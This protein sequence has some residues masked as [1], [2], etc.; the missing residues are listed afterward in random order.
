MRPPS[1]DL[2]RLVKALSK[3]EKR[4]FK[5][6]AG[7]MAGDKKY[8]ELFDL[9]DR[10]ATYDEA[11][12]A[13][14]DLYGGQLSV[15]KNYL[16]RFLLKSLLY[17]NSEPESEMVQ[18]KEHASILATRELPSQALKYIRKSLRIAEKLEAFECMHELHAMEMEI[19]LRQP[20]E[21]EAIDKV[22]HLA[23]AKSQTRSLLENLHHYKDLHAQLQIFLNSKSRGLQQIEPRELLDLEA[24]EHLVDIRKAKSVRAK[25]EFLIT[26]RKLASYRSNWAGA[27]EYCEEALE[28]FDQHPLLIKSNLR[29]Y[30]S[31]LSHLVACYSAQDK[32]QEAGKALENFASLEKR[33]P[34]ARSEYQQTYHLLELGLA[35]RTGDVAR[36]KSLVPSILR[37]IKT[38]GDR[39]PL[40]RI[41]L[42]YYLLAY[43]HFMTGQRS[44][45]LTHLN[46]FLAEPRSESRMNFQALARLLRLLIFFEME[47]YMVVENEIGNVQRFLGKHL[48]KY[49]YAEAI[50]KAL[51]KLIKNAGTAPMESL[52]EKVLLDFRNDIH[53]AQ[54]DKGADMLD[55]ELWIKSRISKKNMVELKL[56]AT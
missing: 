22:L 38:A 43:M 44:Q 24:S 3:G 4:N 23:K 34:Q 18:L 45:A 16:F 19:V 20:G 25:L 36:A 9:V 39:M 27:L 33:F 2:F 47:D 48:P 1:D 26:K 35:I 21:A 15:A 30:F 52:M 13:K 32:V 37:E 28:L 49:P 5:L 51:R 11:K 53:N 12:L 17:Y 55:F 41:L 8:T 10:Q 56:Q 50:L 54:G 29:N 31:E 6:L 7:M 46:A 14:S 40:S 42:T